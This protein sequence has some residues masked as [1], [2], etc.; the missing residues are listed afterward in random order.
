MERLRH[1][2]AAWPA[3]SPAPRAAPGR[4]ADQ[5]A[6]A[7]ELGLPTGKVLRCC[8]A[9]K[10]GMRDRR[11]GDVGSRRSNGRQGD[12]EVGSAIRPQGPQGRPNTSACTAPLTRPPPSLG[13]PNLWP[14]AGV[15]PHK[16]G[17]RRTPRQTAPGQAPKR[18]AVPWTLG[19]AAAPSAAMDS[20][21][22][23]AATPCHAEFVSNASV[24]ASHANPSHAANVKGS[25]KAPPTAISQASA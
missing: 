17:S 15:A 3:P 23:P 22:G 21:P 2:P 8:V 16:M 7:P 11:G 20:W 6:V 9:V 4:S 25:S 14:P 19:E 12:L 1:P 18:V 10:T 24:S 13:F 5:T